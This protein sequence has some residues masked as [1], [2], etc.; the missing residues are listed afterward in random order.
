MAFDEN[1][2]VVP[3]PIPASVVLGESVVSEHPV[4]TPLKNRIAELER[5]VEVVKGNADN[6]RN[7]WNTL[8]SQRYTLENALRTFVEDEEIEIEVAQKL[9]D[10]FDIV[11][12]KT[13]DVELTFKVTVSVEVPLGEEMTA[14]DVADNVSIS[15]D[16]YGTGE[17][18]ESDSDLEDWSERS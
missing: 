1:G 10:I 14:D 7:R 3:D 11:L 16:Y 2:L 9:A 4:L 6:Y 13:I 15:V 12:T 8:T 17:L 5:E 18:L